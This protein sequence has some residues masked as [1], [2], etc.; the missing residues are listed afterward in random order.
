MQQ[1][2][3]TPDKVPVVKK[4]TPKTETTITGALPDTIWTDNFKGENLI[5]VPMRDITKLSGYQAVQNYIK[6]NDDVDVSDVY[7]AYNDKGDLTFYVKNGG[8]IDGG[9]A[10]LDSEVDSPILTYKK[11][12]REYDTF[13]TQMRAVRNARLDGKKNVELFGFK[14]KLRT[15]SLLQDEAALNCDDFM[16]P[17]QCKLIFNFCDP[18]ICPRSRCNYGGRGR[19]D[20][21]V[22]ESG[23]GASVFACLHNFREGVLVPICLTGIQASLENIK[24]YLLGYQRC[25]EIK[26]KE[27]R[28]VGFCDRARS[29]FICEIIWRHFLDPLIQGM[30]MKMTRARKGGGEYKEGPICSKVSSAKSPPSI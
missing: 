20:R 9:N 14:Y 23:L 27:G 29:V 12:T 8:E 26:L 15:K 16:S 18:V 30:S 1:G 19:L 5:V 24:S 6:E 13:T 21:S 10:N 7:A 28:S 3:E 22:Q 11:G 25:L 2:Y 4:D 17:G